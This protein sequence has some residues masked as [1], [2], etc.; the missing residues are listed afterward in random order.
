VVNPVDAVATSMHER[1]NSHNVDNDKLQV[2][3]VSTPLLK[4][5]VFAPGQTHTR[6]IDCTWPGD[7]G[8]YVGVWQRRRTQAPTNA[9]HSTHPSLTGDCQSKYSFGGGTASDRYI[10]IIE[11]IYRVFISIS[12]ISIKHLLW[13]HHHVDV[14]GVREVVATGTIL[15]L[16]YGVNRFW[17]KVLSSKFT[18]RPVGH[19]NNSSTVKPYR[20]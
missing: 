10:L 17:K 15:V 5:L 20:R 16:G 9:L 2:N 6:I 14:G 1:I 13:T 7:S 11:T 12:D 3:F 4:L 18:I 19:H 8:G